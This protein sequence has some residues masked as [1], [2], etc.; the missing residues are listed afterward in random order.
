MQLF[1]ELRRDA[2]NTERDELFEVDV[3]VAEFPELLDKFGRGAVNTQGN[4][5]VFIGL[6]ARLMERAH[7]FRR[8]TVD[9]K[10]DELVVVLDGQAFL[11]ESVNEFRGNAMYA[12]GDELV[13]VLGGQ[14]FLP[15][16][17]NE[18]GGN[19]VDA[20]GD[21]FVG[22]ETFEVF[23]FDPADEIKADIHDGHEELFVFIHR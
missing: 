15:E 19:T 9:A 20:E 21:E 8:D 5:G 10:G 22:V 4:Q 18:F 12:E 14:A 13:A 23:R 1:D 17:V 7:H 2:M 6:V 16:S 3:V 11:A